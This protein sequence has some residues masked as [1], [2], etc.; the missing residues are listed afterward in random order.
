MTKNFAHLG[1]LV[2]AIAIATLM[3][4]P[5]TSA[6]SS[7]AVSPFAA[8]ATS[9]SG[10]PQAVA[11]PAHASPTASERAFPAAARAT[12]VAAR[13]SAALSKAGVP[14]KN[15]LLPNLDPNVAIQNGMITPGYS[16]VPAPMG[17]AD[18]G[19]QDQNGRN[20][21]TNSL[22]SSVEG[23]LTMNQL[24]LLYLDSAGPDEFTSQLNTI[25]VNVTVHG[26]ASYQ[27]WTQNVI[28]Y[29][30]STN[31]LHLADAVVNFSSSA[32]LFPANTIISG[33]GYIAPGFGYFYPYGPTIHVPDPFTIQFYNN[34]TVVNGNAAVDFN[35][36]II[37][38][39][40]GRISGSYD[41][42]VFN[43][44]APGGTPHAVAPLYEISGE[45]LSDTGYIP[46]DAELILG[47]DGGGST[48]SIFN[49]DA[50]M[51][52]FLEAAGSTTY[53][54]AP[55]VYDFGSETGE[56]VEGIAEWATDTGGVPVVHLGPGPAV[57]EPLWG[58]VGAPAFG[59]VR[60][61]LT[62]DPANA[63][64]F[65]SAGRTFD[66][67]TAAWAPLSPSGTA[68]YWLPPGRYTFQYLLS[69]YAPRTET[70]H[71]TTMRTI[72]LRADSSL[73]V[74]TPLWAFGNGEL[75]AISQSGAGT[76]GNPYVLENNEP[77]PLNPLFGQ[78][79][80]YFFPEFPGVL[81]VGTT[82]YVSV[83]YL[84]SPTVD[85]SLS[86]ESFYAGGFGLPLSNQLG[87]NFYATSHVSLVGSPDISS[88][89]F[90]DDTGESESTVVFW[91]STHD[92]IAANTFQVES[93]GLFFYG[94][95]HNTIWGNVLYPTVPSGY[96]GA[97]LAYQD[98]GFGLELFE[99]H[100]LIYNN[101]F[102]TGITAY[103]PSFD[104][105]SFDGVFATWVDRWDVHVQP[106]T[107]VRDVNGWDLSGNILGLSWEGGNYWWNYGTATDPFGVYPYDNGGLIE[108][109]GDYHPLYPAP[110]Y[111]ITFSEVG[112][113]AGTYWWVTIN[114]Y[115]Q[116]TSG[117][118]LVFYEPNGTYN[119]TVG[120][121]DGYLPGH[122]IGT[123][124]VDGTSVSRTIHFHN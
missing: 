6:G 49:I 97:S 98:Y 14:A 44:S 45:Y 113:P 83:A 79:N 21:A 66:P 61:Q 82:A 77:G 90:A 107:D 56:T 8:T 60:I 26:N 68:T 31:T 72:D 118:V 16:T 59:A 28:Y 3:T 54:A 57:Q 114:G 78:F 111:A 52:L 93:Y 115:T 48:A 17:I 30:Q 37:S 121:T 51:Q 65:A 63:F 76:V 87:F 74:Y 40:T 7:V 55:A 122:E 5:S 94:G 86:W 88:W 18:Y 13:M 11:G 105:Y 95:A 70:Y 35:Y 112:L 96:T 85:Y 46:L 120:A 81:L 110:I 2:L 34:L 29:Y 89:W 108:F 15:Q 32:F 106:A 19:I 123:I 103:S 36:T 50:T 24:S 69:D 47:G 20:V 71:S 10:G 117:T 23:S 104:I 116:E 42:V 25:A 84:A 33:N 64:V 43:S 124:V 1:L 62:V 80:D 109:G 22:Y 92:L 39:T 67:N 101:A 38:S 102:E 9:P 27:F 53:A 91:N 100:D 12:A 58:V 99:S 73:G 41:Q 75:A 119:Y 4:L